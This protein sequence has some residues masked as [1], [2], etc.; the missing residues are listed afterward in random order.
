MGTALAM[1]R[2]E[3][4]SVDARPIGRKRLIQQP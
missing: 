4:F 3:A 2:P 1:L